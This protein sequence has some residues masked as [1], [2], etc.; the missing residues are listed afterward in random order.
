MNST[1]LYH[2]EDISWEEL[3]AIGIEKSFLHETGQFETL[4]SG[5]ITEPM[6]FEITL[7][8]VPICMDASLQLATTSDGE[9]HILIEG[10]QF[11]NA[12]SD[13]PL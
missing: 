7:L 4:L 11:H 6:P 3:S 9:I 13:N 1:R 10:M 8:G 5:K 2:E 12:Q